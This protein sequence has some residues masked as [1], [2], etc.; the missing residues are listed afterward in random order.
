LVARFRNGDAAD[1]PIDP[2]EPRPQPDAQKLH[3]LVVEDNDI[4]QMVMQTYL[5][6][7]GHKATVVDSAEAALA[8]LRDVR[9]DVILMDVNLPGL[10]GTAATRAI[11]AMEDTKIS[12]MPIIGISAHVQEAERLEN[13]R[14]GMSAVLTKP[15]S[16]ETLQATLRD[17]VMQTHA[18]CDLV[19]DIGA[20]RAGDLARRFLAGLPKGLA[21][22]YDPAVSKDYM[23]LS[24]AAH[25]LKSAAGNFDLPALTA[26]LSRIETLAKVGESS[27]LEAGLAQ[28]PAAID[29]ARLSL[30][31][32]LDR[33]DTSLNQAAQ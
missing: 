2:P 22:I 29:H 14:A 25:Q 23:K 26:L 19:V 10:S 3:A 27:E 18:L 30:T 1:L 17:Q 6:D 7:M 5:E 12:T 13:L 4:N 24:R 32:A 31:L 16:P 21:A 8:A 28:M 11:R 15:L 20:E 33:I 9:F